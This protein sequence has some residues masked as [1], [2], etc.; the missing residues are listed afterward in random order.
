MPHTELIQS[1]IEDLSLGRQY[2]LVIVPSNIL[3]LVDRV[4]SAAKHIT[5]DGALAFELTNPYWLRAG[6]GGGVRVTSFDG[7]G[8]PGLRPEALYKA[9]LSVIMAGFCDWMKSGR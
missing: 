2:E 4:R 3:C 8:L 1:R 5:A 9:E 6:A 7:D